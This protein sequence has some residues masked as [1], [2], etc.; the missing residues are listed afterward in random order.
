MI[1]EQ[2]K[3]K[4]SAWTAQKVLETV[5]AFSE[6]IPVFNVRGKTKVST[7]AGGILT[8]LVAAVVLMYGFIRFEHMLSKYNP[9]INDYYVDLDEEQV[10]NFNEANFRFAFTIE[11]FYAPRELKDNEKYV[12]W[13]VRIY[14]AE[15]GEG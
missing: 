15:N 5:D 10:G 12:K 14:G 7:G 6:P 8:L 11:D 4:R 3:K 2:D 1:R 9:N 13:A